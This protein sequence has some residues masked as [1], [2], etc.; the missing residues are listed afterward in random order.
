MRLIVRLILMVLVAFSASSCID[1]VE[2]YNLRGNG[3][4]TASFSLQTPAFTPVLTMAGR[5]I[6]NQWMNEI[7]DMPQKTAGKLKT[8]RG[9]SEVKTLNLLK[10]GKLGISF[11]FDNNKA[12][13]KALYA[14]MNLDKKWYYPALMKVKKHKLKKRNIGPYLKSYLEKKKSN[15][16]D[17]E[18]LKMVDYKIIYH[19]PAEVK[20]TKRPLCSNIICLLF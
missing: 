13:D 14:L 8:I 20:K 18:L 1:I 16:K 3:S 4:G 10:E 5:Y 17:E 12:L 15:L 6:D 19:L 2:E 9:I 11:S 7:V